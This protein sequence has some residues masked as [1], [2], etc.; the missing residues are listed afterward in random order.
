MNKII[1]ILLLFPAL[2]GALILRILRPVTV[3]R[4][5]SLDI[6][7]IGGIYVGDWHLSERAAGIHDKKN[8]DIFYFTT[9]D[10]TICNR[11]WLK[12]WQRVL[13]TVPFGRLFSMIN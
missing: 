3:I 6:S 1:K 2:L 5:G 9:T 12:M 10:N 13:R 11:Q 4:L 8:F 7:R